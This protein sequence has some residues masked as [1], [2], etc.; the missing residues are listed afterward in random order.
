MLRIEYRANK[1]SYQESRKTGK[2]EKAEA[3]GPQGRN[4]LEKSVYSVGHVLS[5]Q[6][7]QTLRASVNVVCRIK[8]KEAGFWSSFL[9]KC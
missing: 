7:K 1:G 5:A 8:H 3:I 9:K 4:L 6:Y 2:I